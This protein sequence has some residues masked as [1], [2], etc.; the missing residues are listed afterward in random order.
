VVVRE[1][2]INI[3]GLSN[4]KSHQFNFELG[5]EFFRHYGSEL[6]PGGQFTAAV[7]LNKHETFIE[8]DFN[9][10]GKANLVCD[11]TLEAF[12]YPIKIDKKIVFK[13]GHEEGEVSDEIVI[14][15]YDRTT[16]EL[17]QYMY[18]FIGL[19]IP[20]K[21]LHP[22]LQEDENDDDAPEGKLIYSSA[23]AED[24]NEEEQTDPRW[25]KLKK[26]K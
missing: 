2:S 24:N 26:L 17:G 19:E 1:F 20:I 25:E 11:R 5:D 9:I 3:V 22:K 13:Y 15:G 18:E 6:V 10:R 23:T 12:D 16:L 21:K 8:A 7:V 14:I 4:N